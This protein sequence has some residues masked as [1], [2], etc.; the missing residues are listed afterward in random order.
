MPAISAASFTASTA[1]PRSRRGSFLRRENA[2]RLRRRF[3]SVPVEMERELTVEGDLLIVRERL[4]MDGKRPVEV[5]WGHH[6]TFGS[7]LLAGPFEISHRR[8]NGRIGRT[9]PTIR[10]PIRWCPARKANGRPLR[11]RA[12]V[13]W[14]CR[15]R[16]R[17][18]RR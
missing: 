3:F 18:R 13:R 9:V 5:M 7:D 17:R 2:I 14:I 12:A 8:R 10:R 1:R 16:P 4:K 15:S 11:G 6:T